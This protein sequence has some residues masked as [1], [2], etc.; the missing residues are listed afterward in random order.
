VSGK[1]ISDRKLEPFSG[2]SRSIYLTPLTKVG[3]KALQSCLC[4]WVCGC[5]CVR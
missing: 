4:V 5:V 1:F 3:Q 2:R